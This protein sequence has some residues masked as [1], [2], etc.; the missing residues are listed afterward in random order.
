MGDFATTSQQSTQQNPYQQNTDRI[1]RKIFINRILTTP[2]GRAGR[3]PGRERD[4]QSDL[5]HLEYP[6]ASLRVDC[7]HAFF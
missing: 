4:C 2:L 7:Y 3:V 1:A 5:Y 6:G